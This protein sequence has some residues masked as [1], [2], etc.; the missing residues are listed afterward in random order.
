[1]VVVPVLVQVLVLLLLLVMVLVL[2]QNDVAQLTLDCRLL[3]RQTHTPITRSSTTM[4]TK[5]KTTTTLMKV[6]GTGSKGLQQTTAT[7]AAKAPALA[8][9]IS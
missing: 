7:K 2:L 3:L 5:V 6:T 1:V 4:T 9:S 8:K